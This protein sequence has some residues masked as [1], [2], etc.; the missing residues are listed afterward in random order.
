[1]NRDQ[2]EV[3]ARDHQD[4]HHL[5]DQDVAALLRVAKADVVKPRQEHEADPEGG[6]QNQVFPQLE[7]RE[8]R[9]SRQRDGAQRDRDVVLDA[10]ELHRP[11]QVAEQGRRGDDDQAECQCPN[12]PLREQFRL[13]AERDRDQDHRGENQEA[14]ITFG[15][16][17]RGGPRVPLFR[18]RGRLHWTRGSLLNQSPLPAGERVSRGVRRDLAPPGPTPS[19]GE[20]PLR[21]RGVKHD[22]VPARPYRFSSR[23]TS[24][25]SGVETSKMSAS[26]TAVMR[27]RVRGGRCTE[28]PS[29]M[30]SFSSFPSRLP[31]SMSTAPSLTSSHSSL[32][33]WY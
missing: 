20:S 16:D 12:L 17:R 26:S 13:E 6:R 22:H 28:S 11:T 1:M 14:A 15:R 7:A 30:R 31:I 21:E 33:S 19:R 29:R 18:D 8:D 2:D 9:K 5:L 25:I 27:W 3:G 24:S 32:R 23:T 10:R 4:E